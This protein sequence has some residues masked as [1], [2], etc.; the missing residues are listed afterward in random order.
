MN[1]TITL[2]ACFVTI[3]AIAQE[4]S[5]KSKMLSDV[6][7]TGQYKPQSVKN[8]VYQVRTISKEIIQ[9]LGAAKIED[10]LGKQINFRFSQDVSTGGSGITMLGLKGQNIKILLD[11][12][13]VL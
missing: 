4:D 10:V 12:L 9:K 6:V 8:S 5:T 3:N 11:G 2:L 7:V 13:P 1:K